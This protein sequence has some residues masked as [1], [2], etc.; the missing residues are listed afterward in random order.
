MSGFQQSY[1][2]PRTDLENSSSLLAQPI[3]LTDVPTYVA[4]HGQFFFIISVSVPAEGEIANWVFM[5]TSFW[6]I[7]ASVIPPSTVDAQFSADMFYS[8]GVIDPCRE[9]FSTAD[10]G[11]SFATPPCFLVPKDVF[12]AQLRPIYKLF[13]PPVAAHVTQGDILLRRTAGGTTTHSSPKPCAGYTVYS[14]DGFPH[15]CSSKLGSDRVIG[16]G[17]LIRLTEASRFDLLVKQLTF[18]VIFYRS[19]IIRFSEMSHQQILKSSHEMFSASQW[20]RISQLPVCQDN[21]AGLA[22]LELLLLGHA[23]TRDWTVLSWASF[24]RS[25]PFVKW[26]RD[27]TANGRRQLA[28]CLEGFQSVVR[29]FH[30]ELFADFLQ[31]LIDEL[32]SNADRFQFFADILIAV[33]VWNIIASVYHSVSN[34]KGVSQV[35][36]NKDMSTPALVVAL[37]K[38]VCADCLSDMATNKG[39][40][41]MYPHALFFG[42]AGRLHTMKMNTSTSRPSSPHSTSSVGS[43]TSSKSSKPPKKSAKVSFAATPT[44]LASTSHAIKKVPVCAWF[45]ASELRLEDTSISPPKPFA[46]RLTS[47][48]CN[49]MPLRTLTKD[50]ARLAVSKAKDD[51]VVNKARADL[52]LDGI[53]RGRRTSFK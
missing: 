15:V 49:H 16:L 40:W 37:F 46:C 39:P 17:G 24:H 42:E 7:F 43:T 19:E 32:L 8:T 50:A 41:T 28:G 25:G 23:D 30:G 44:P 1:S 11:R 3:P 20:T 12:L 26:T 14:L 27:C 4:N 10:R 6:G 31:P 33:N 5:A 38:S 51:N 52:I 18:D 47:K 36:P 2:D 21:P 29:C 35:F 13:V 45:I 48:I 22:A 34:E 53:N 9:L